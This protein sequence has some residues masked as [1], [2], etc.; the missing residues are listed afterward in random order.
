M[1]DSGFLLSAGT[2]AMLSAIVIQL[3]KKSELS[4]F[5]FLGTDK[6]KAQANF[7]FSGLVAF[8]TSIGISYKY[9][10]VAGTLLLTG[11]TAIAIGHGLWH[12]FIQWVTQHV[13]Y[14]AFVVPSELQAININVLNQLLAQLKSEHLEQPVEVK[15]VK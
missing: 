3:L 9:D 7:V 8:I 14:K 5:N 6:T 1:D 4:L 10:P 2:T 13:A 15:V 11:I 12:W